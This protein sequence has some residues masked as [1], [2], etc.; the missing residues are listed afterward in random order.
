[1]DSRTN[2]YLGSLILTST[3]FSVKNHTVYHFFNSTTLY[4]Q[5]CIY[6]KV[7]KPFISLVHSGLEIF[8]VS[9]LKYKMANSPSKKRGD[10]QTSPSTNTTRT[11]PSD[12]CSDA[13]SSSFSSHSTTTSSSSSSSLSSQHCKDRKKNSR[14]KM[15]RKKDKKKRSK[16]RCHKS[17]SAVDFQKL[18][19]QNSLLVKQ[20]AKVTSM[21]L[22]LAYALDKNLKRESDDT[23]SSDP[24]SSHNF[25]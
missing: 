11:K 21:N 3:Y 17:K 7:H 16:K 9:T 13:N 10:T 12:T 15:K 4:V 6:Q 18:L 8:C 24:N 19:D 20:L 5:R 23:V 1:M 22:K 25:S 14:S 2:T